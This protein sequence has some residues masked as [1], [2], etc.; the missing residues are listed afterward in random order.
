MKF[1]QRQMIMLSE[2]KKKLEKEL[3]KDKEYT[4]L[5]N[6]KKEIFNYI[7]AMKIGKNDETLLNKY[8][9]IGEQIKEMEIQKTYELSIER[10]TRVKILGKIF[11]INK[12]KKED[13]EDEFNKIVEDTNY[14]NKIKKRKDLFEKL[15]KKSK[16]YQELMYELESIETEISTM[17]SEII[18]KMLKGQNV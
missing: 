2:L 6:R 1:N 15:S 3:K 10:K 12:S 8:G 18:K 4:K 17:E 5:I 11:W 7:V 9:K 13:Y 16:K 14:K